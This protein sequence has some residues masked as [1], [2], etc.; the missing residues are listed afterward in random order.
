MIELQR[1]PGGEAAVF[2]RAEKGDQHIGHDRYHMDVGAGMPLPGSNN[3][4]GPIPHAI[5]LY[6]PSRA[7]PDPPR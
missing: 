5:D 2:G 3:R 1:R 4:L 6:P 7:A